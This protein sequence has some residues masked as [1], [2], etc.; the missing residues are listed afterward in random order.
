MSRIRPQQILAPT[1][2]IIPRKSNAPNQHSVNRFAASRS[3]ESRSAGAGTHESILTVLVVEDEAVSRKLA[4]M[5]LQRKGYSVLLANT[6]VEALQLLNS[7]QVDV[8]LMDITMPEM[9]GLEAATLIRDREYGTNEHLP[10][11]AVTAN[12]MQIDKERGFEVGMDAYI[13]KPYQID[14]LLNTIEIVLENKPEQNA[15]NSA[16]NGSRIEPPIADKRP[17]LSQMHGVEWRD[18][19]FWLRERESADVIDYLEAENRYTEAMTQH[20]ADLCE[21]LY[22]EMRGR[23]QEA[24][25]SVPQQIDSFFYY[26]RTEEGSQYAI[27]CRRRGSMDGPEEIILDENVLAAEFDY[28]E[29]GNF[30]ISPD[31][32][33]LAYTVDTDGS[34]KYTLYVKDLETGRLLADRANG[35]SYGL[36][37]GNDNETL[38]YVTQDD[39]FRSDKLVR[40][41]LGDETVN[42]VV[43]HHETDEAYFVNLGKTKSKAYLILAM[44]SSV[45]SEAWFIPADAP[46][47]APQI[48]HPR[49]QNVEYDVEHHAD[50]FI[51]VTNDRAVNFRVMVAPVDAPAKAN[52][53]EVIAHREHVKIDGVEPF[54]NYWVIYERENGLRQI[55]VRDLARDVD[56]RVDFP[57]SVYTFA[58]SGNPNFES[59]TLRFTYASLTT[60][61]SVY[62]YGMADHAW[63]LRKQKP[64]LGGFDAAHYEAERLFATA[65]DGAKIPISLVRRKDAPRD[66][67]APLLLYGY[68]SYGVSIDPTFNA[69][70]ISLLD[71]G[72]TFAIAHVRGGGTMG[73]QW[74]E[75]GKFLH[76]KNTFTDFVACAEHLVEKGYTT[77][78]QLVANGRSAG[79]LL[80]GAITNLR[81]DLFAGVV[82]G[83][84]FMDVI[85]TM[86]DE[87]IP[88][89]VIE[90]GEWGNPNDPE[91]FEYMMSYS[92]YDNVEAKAYPNI[93]ATAGLNDPRVQYWEPAKWVA[94]LRTLKTDSNLVLL[95]TNMGAGHSGAS[96]R[97]DYLEELAFEFAFM[98]DVWGLA[99]K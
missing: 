93:L 62:E 74:Y 49:E 65:A 33:L 87:S 61:D 46:T 29:L 4:T 51:I 7:N 3:A 5:L 34:E 88:L 55:C 82:A 10:I 53:R 23:I 11:I 58:R 6:G 98:L 76:K 75:N 48:I 47:T 95:K 99:G 28:F 8:V 56:V 15:G 40:H 45:T 71:R 18:N 30:A 12:A 9:G 35:L 37:W 21:S 42:D 38:F 36:E 80:M 44:H 25:T 1:N 91:F 66:M 67:A 13:T 32:R 17:H 43:L 94:K 81:P 72:V 78:A 69:N 60:P 22:Q 97:F 64:V 96:G 86:L 84:P 54:C 39:A 90:Y 14:E 31:H 68:G 70:R 41:R 20:N 50:Q 59:N 52:W 63:T 77:P 79:G 85:N 73:R 24:D 57:E 89:T 92:P 2:N 26:V 16:G 27:H 19:Y 83:V